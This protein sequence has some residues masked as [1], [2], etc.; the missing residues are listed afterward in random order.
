MDERT[1]LAATGLEAFETAE[2]RSPNWT[3]ADRAWADRVALDAVACRGAARGLRRRARPARAAAAR[4]ARAGAGA[5]FG[6]VVAGGAL[7]RRVAVLLA[8]V[9]GLLAD[10]L[11]RRAPHQ[12]AGAADVGRARLERL[13]LPRPAGLAAGAAQPPQR[14]PARADRAQRGRA[15]RAGASA[16]RGSPAGGSAAA[17]HRFAALWLERSR[18]LATRRAE[19]L[20]H[21]AAAALALGLIAGLYLR[22]LVFD[23]RAGWEST[24]L[25]PEAAHAVVSTLLAPAA[26]LSGIALPDVAAFAALRA[27]HGAS[28]RRRAGGD[29]DPPARADA[30]AAWWCC[31]AH[32]SRWLAPRGRAGA[33][34]ASRC[35]STSRTSSAWRGC[36]SGGSAQVVVFPY[37]STPS[38]QATLGLRAVLA[39]GVRAAA[40]ARVAPRRSAFGAEDERRRRRCPPE[41]RTRSPC[42]TWGRR[43]R[44]RTRA[45]SCARWPRRCRRRGARRAASTSRQFARRFAGLGERLAAAARRMARLGA[46]RVGVAPMAR[47]SRSGPTSPA[48]EAACRPRSRVACAGHEPMRDAAPPA[49]RRKPTT[50]GGRSIALSLVSHTNAGKT[51]LARTLLR[52]RRRRGA[53]RAA[54]HRVRRRAHDDRRRADGERLLLWDT[55][56]FG[57]SV[58]LV[59]APAAGAAARSA[60]S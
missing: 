29:V 56:G 13:R 38:P 46:T 14:R 26:R 47:R 30:G 51:T 33:R 53:R 32:C 57:D 22:G 54:R 16:C 37:G 5:A 19:T 58:R 20:L 39:R 28:R 43:R 50:V 18:G 23:Y 27:V 34:R 11:G 2:P 1:A 41:H 42:S 31:R 59:Q 3:D 7:D 4:T 60:G 52:P 6:A 40:R 49:C 21:A 24:F 8:F 36:S 17:L 25:T 48:S 12:P 45:A 9:V 10:A 55:P 35:R 44:P 15:D